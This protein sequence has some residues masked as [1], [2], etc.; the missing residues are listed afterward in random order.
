MTLWPLS[1]Q[2]HRTVSPT[3]M[4]TVSGHKHIATLSHR[5]IENLT[6]TRWHAAHGWPS[7]LIHNVDAGGR[8]LFLCASCATFVARFSLRQ[9]YNRKHRCQPKSQP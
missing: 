3:E 9:K 7:V 5:H 2:V 8:R 1:A 6:G 4:L